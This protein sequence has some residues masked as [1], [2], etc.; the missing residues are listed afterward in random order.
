MAVTQRSAEAQPLAG[1]RVLVTRPAHQA[2]HLCALIEAAGGTAVRFPTIQI[3]PP[4]NPA[5]LDDIIARLEEFDLVIFVSPNAV[6]CAMERI[7]AQRSGLPT[8][9]A[10]AC[11]GSGSARAL[12]GFGVQ[13]VITPSTRTDSEGLLA[14]PPLQHVTGYR[15]VLFRGEGGRELLADT[16]AARGAKIEQAECYRRVPPG[17]DASEVS[18]AL[19]QG[20]IDTVAITSADGAHNLYEMLDDAAREALTR[21]AIVTISKR[22]WEVCRTMGLRGPVEVAASASDEAIVTALAITSRAWHGSQKTL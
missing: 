10:V 14:L 20:A 12:A 2:E 7:Q 19:A 5:A 17:T 18:R 11:V 16:L 15:I 6:Q 22:L 13:H 1:R 4:Q 9:L 21:A 3:A 8:R